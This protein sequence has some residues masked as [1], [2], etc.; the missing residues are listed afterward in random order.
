MP[1]ISL[2]AKSSSINICAIFSPFSI[3]GFAKEG[4]IDLIAIFYHLFKEENCLQIFTWNGN[5]L[6]CFSK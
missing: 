2:I 4:S 3:P 1:A 5:I 6:P